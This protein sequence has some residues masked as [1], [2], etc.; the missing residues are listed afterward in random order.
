MALAATGILS[1]ASCGGNEN[2]PTKAPS[3][4]PEIITPTPD[5]T[6]EETETNQ[7]FE[8]STKVLYPDGTEVKEFSIQWCNDESC[9]PAEIKATNGVAKKQFTDPNSHYYPHL[10]TKN[11]L[12][13]YVYDI[14]ACIQTKDNPEATIQLYSLNTPTGEG[15]D[16]SPFVITEGGIRVTVTAKGSQGMKTYKFVAPKAGRYEIESVVQ[17]YAGAKNIDTTV[18]VDSKQDKDSGIN[19]NFK[20]AFDTTEGQE[21]IIKMLVS[22]AGTDISEKAPVSFDVI[23]REVK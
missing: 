13:K 1:L 19:K 4:T 17:F 14:N 12:D 11:L 9:F 15:T 5:P 6:D 8:L 22:D 16:A 18:K 23:L 2:E 20:L 10:T 3:K 7:S 21:V